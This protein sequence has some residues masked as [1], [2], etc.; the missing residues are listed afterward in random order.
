[1]PQENAISKS[2][3]QKLISTTA[4]HSKERLL[5]A[6]DQPEDLINEAIFWTSMGNS[7]VKLIRIGKPK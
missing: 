3:E 1:M 5:Y 4:A 6:G 2:E 7:S